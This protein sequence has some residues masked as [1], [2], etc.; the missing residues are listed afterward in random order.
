MKK[1]FL[2]AA[3]PSASPYACQIIAACRQQGYQVYGLGDQACQDAGMHCLVQ[4]RAISVVGW[5]EVVRHFW[6]IIQA[7][8]LMKRALRVHRPQLVVLIDYPGFNLRFAQYA[9]KLGLRVA[10]LSPP[11]V[12]AWKKERISILQETQASL[13]VLLPFESDYYRQAGLTATLITHPL[14]ASCVPQPMNHA[15]LKRYGLDHRRPILCLLPGSR[16]QEIKRMM[17][18]YL[19]TV[20]QLRQWLP[21][22][23][24]FLLHTAVV[25]AQLLQPWAQAFIEHRV[26]YVHADLATGLS[27][28]TAVLAMSGTVTL[29][30][31][32]LEKP[33]TIACC[34]HPFNYWLAK[35]WVRVPYLGLCNLVARADIVP[36][37]LQAQ[38]TFMALATSLRPML[39]HPHR[40]QAAYKKVRACLVQEKSQ[41]LAA[42]VDS[43]LAGVR[44]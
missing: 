42:W 20:C 17:P 25:E 11:Q 8:V 30:V 1:V 9:K 34:T 10:Y 37:F 7:W 19:A 15:L 21:G 44:G 18:L 28:A 22:L 38:A 2:I 16:R 32:L 14:L 27:C 29:E 33:M 41:S 23:Q 6:P 26:A 39:Q 43:L 36:E 4:A 12:W 40:Y 31:A 3:E 35:K 13:G 5:L 24:V